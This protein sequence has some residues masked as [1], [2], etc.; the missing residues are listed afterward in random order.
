MPDDLPHA[1]GNGD[2]ARVRRWFDVAGKPALGGLANHFPANDDWIRGNLEWS[3]PRKLMFSSGT[4]YAGLGF[5]WNS[6]PFRR[7][8]QFRVFECSPYRMSSSSIRRKLVP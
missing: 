5:P 4:L 8:N 7:R 3:E 1:A 2:F 6:I